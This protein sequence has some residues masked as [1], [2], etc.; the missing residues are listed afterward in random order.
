MVLM[1]KATAKSAPRFEGQHKDGCDHD[2]GREPNC[3]G[4]R[5]PDRQRNRCPDHDAERNQRHYNFA[6]DTSESWFP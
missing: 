3:V 1:M 2:R 4:A 5:E 6:D